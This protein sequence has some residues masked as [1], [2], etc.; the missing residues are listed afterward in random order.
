MWLNK[1]TTLYEQYGISPDRVANVVAIAIN[2]LED[3]N[4]NKFTI[5]PTMQ[6]W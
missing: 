1:T 6:P 5:G 3:T 2:Q 4:V